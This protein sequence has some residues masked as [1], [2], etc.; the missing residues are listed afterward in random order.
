VRAT[1]LHLARQAD[2]FE[3]ALFGRDLH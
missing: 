1:I 3:R 2:D